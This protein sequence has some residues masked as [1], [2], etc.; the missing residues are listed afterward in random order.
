MKKLFRDYQTNS[1]AVQIAV[2]NL[3]DG[4]EADIGTGSQW[5]TVKVKS[6]RYT[7][8]TSKFDFLEPGFEIKC[9]I[10]EVSKVK[11]AGEL[12]NNHYIGALQSAFEPIFESFDL[13]W[14]ATVNGFQDV[15][16]YF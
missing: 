9:A 3:R 6:F 13:D 10:K 5:L 8:R 2:Q 12:D 14:D 15:T 11:H 1:Q 7:V 4:T 16:D